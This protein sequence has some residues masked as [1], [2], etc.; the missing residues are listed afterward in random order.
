MASTV[1][2]KQLRFQISE[3]CIKNVSGV[4]SSLTRGTSETIQIL[5]ADVPGGF[6]GFLPFLLHLL[7]G[8]SHYN[9]L[10]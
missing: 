7:I 3:T 9:E 4:G 2:T 1:T 5:L 8:L 6:L 10:K